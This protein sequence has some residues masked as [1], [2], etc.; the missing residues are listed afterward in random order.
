MSDPVT[1]KIVDTT[2]RD[3]SHAIAHQYRVDPD[4]AY[5]PG[6]RQRQGCGQLRSGT[7]TGS[8]LTQSS[9]DGPCTPIP[10]C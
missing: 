9:T 1:V 5:R 6:A 3:G 7:A 4:D 10:S 2:L 8:A